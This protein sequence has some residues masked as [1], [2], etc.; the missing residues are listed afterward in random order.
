MVHNYDFDEIQYGYSMKNIPTPPKKEYLLTLLHMI[1]S[2][3][4]RVK[5]K[6][7]HI[8]TPPVQ[9]PLKDKIVN[10]VIMAPPPLYKWGCLNQK[11]FFKPSLSFDF[12]K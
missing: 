4:G 11:I 6:A 7:Y 12:A 8:L 2:F 1:H 5:W 10:L 9:P 3:V